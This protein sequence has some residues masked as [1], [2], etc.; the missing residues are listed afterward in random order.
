MV[1]S[2][3]PAPGRYGRT[4]GRA[5][6]VVR[7]RAGARFAHIAGRAGQADALGAAVRVAYAIDLP[8]IGKRIA[9]SELSLTGVG[10]GQWLAELQGAD[11]APIEA[12]LGPA[13]GAHAILVDQSHA[14]VIW[15]LD[16]PR[17]RDVLATGLPVDLH[18]RAFGPGDAAATRLAHIGVIVWQLDASPVYEMVVPRSLVGSWW[19]WL[20]A[21]AARHGLEVCAPIG[22]QG[23]GP[24]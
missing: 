13:L 22:G 9:G 6:L 15:R 5:G 2:A 19:H 17:V 16:G 14:R 4:N 18:P 10:P 24:Q 21:N 11:P 23:T 1:D 3:P 7:E 12:R 20:T 8:G